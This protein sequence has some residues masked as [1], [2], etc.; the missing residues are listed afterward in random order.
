MT[1]FVVHELS[2]KTDISS[3]AVYG[4]IRFINHRYIFADELDGDKPPKGFYDSILRSAADFL[5][6]KDYL[7][8]AGD[9]L[10]LVMMAS[11]LTELHAGFTV[12]RYERE[13]KGYIP[14]TIGEIQ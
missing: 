5:P 3:A 11:A 2:P 9:H 7:L 8:I 10:Q 14:V 1:V 13:A 6:K 4:D 12:L